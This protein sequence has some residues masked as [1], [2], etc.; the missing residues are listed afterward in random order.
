MSGVCRACRL[1]EPCFVFPH[2]SVELIEVDIC[3]NWA[4][5]RPLRRTG[6]G[7]VVL[8]LLHIS[9]FQDFPHEADERL[10]VNSFTQDVDQYMVVKAVKARFNVSLD[11]P[12]CACEGLLNLRERSMAAPLGSES[13]RSV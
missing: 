3:K 7:H 9:G 4:H 6:I 10:I 2:I 8:P 11:K 13:M 1:V 12:F 5:S